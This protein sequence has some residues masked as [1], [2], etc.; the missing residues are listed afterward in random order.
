MKTRTAFVSNSSTTSFVCLGFTHNNWEE[1]QEKYGGGHGDDEDSDFECH[2]LSHDKYLVGEIWNIYSD[3]MKI[4][5]LSLKE[6]EQK[7]QEVSAKYNV[8]VEDI[9]LYFGTVAS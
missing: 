8:S 9:Q 6:L 7:A 5:Q 3:S 2:Y 1:L 4:T